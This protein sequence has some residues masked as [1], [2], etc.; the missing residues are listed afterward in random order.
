[1]FQPITVGSV[2]LA[3]RTW[4]PAMVPWRASEAGDITPSVLAWYER[5]AR[6]RPAD[7]MRAPRIR[8]KIRR[9]GFN[10][11]IV[12]AGGIHHFNQA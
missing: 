1:M 4:V 10:T 12:L 9:A 6:G 8:S 11:P 3:S 2:R 5:F 7:G